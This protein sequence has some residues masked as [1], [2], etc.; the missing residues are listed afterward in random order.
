V[1]EVSKCD[2]ERETRDISCR[3]RILKLKS[4][5]ELQRLLVRA[6]EFLRELYE[7]P[8]TQ[9]LCSITSDLR[10][11]AS[12]RTVIK[13]YI[14]NEEDQDRN[15]RRNNE[16]WYTDWTSTTSLKKEF[17]WNYDIMKELG[18]K[19]KLLHFLPRQRRTNT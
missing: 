11:Q 4:Y 1:Q 8:R 13:I 14:K 9:R 5:V 16:Q 12:Q 18:I 10:P 6:K 19:P 3:N 2:E 15:A 7:T 17:V